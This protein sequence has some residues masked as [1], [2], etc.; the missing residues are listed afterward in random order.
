MVLVLE[1]DLFLKGSKVV[2]EEDV[3]A[4]SLKGEEQEDGSV[5]LIQVFEAGEGM[6]IEFV[7]VVFLR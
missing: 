2:G 4:R 6:V 7:G 3:E 5:V 1:E